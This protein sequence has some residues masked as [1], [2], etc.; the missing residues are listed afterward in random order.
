VTCPPPA[1]LATRPPAAPPSLVCPSL[2]TR[3][4]LAAVSSPAPQHAH[5][6]LPTPSAGPI[7]P[8]P[9]HTYPDVFIPRRL[10]PRLPAHLPTPHTDAC[11]TP[12]PCLQHPCPRPQVTPCTAALSTA[13][14]RCACAPPGWA[15]T[16]LSPRL[17]AWWRTRRWAT[18]G[19]GMSPQPAPPRA[20][21][22]GCAGRRSACPACAGPLLALPAHPPRPSCCCTDEQGAHPGL[23]GPRFGRVCARGGGGGCRHLGGLVCGGQTGLVPRRLAARGGAS[24]APAG[25]APSTCCWQPRPVPLRASGAGLRPV[26]STPFAQHVAALL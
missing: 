10:W 2:A 21:F 5:H 22:T 8:S 9:T 16:P 23:C 12:R 4:S 20:C 6:L 7:R 18:A 25:G 3:I 19:C 24:L 26:V 15:P 14:G 1:C 11:I 13:E 17:C